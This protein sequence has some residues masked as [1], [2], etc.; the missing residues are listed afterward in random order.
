MSKDVMEWRRR[1]K[2]RAVD[3]LGGRCM[4]CGYSKCI[5]ALQFHHRDPKTKSFGLSISSTRSWERI[6]TELDKC[7]LLCANC[8]AEVENEI[9]WGVGKLAIRSA[10]NGDIG[11]SSPPAP[12]N[13][14]RSSFGG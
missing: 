10:V 11:G 6:R 5:R 9:Y 1:T 8:H 3:Y 4:R 2:R 14:K 13:L 7:D 12:A